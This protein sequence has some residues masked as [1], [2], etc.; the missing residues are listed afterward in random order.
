MCVCVC[1]RFLDASKVD[2]ALMTN[3]SIYECGRIVRKKK[4]AKKTTV[5]AYS[6]LRINTIAILGCWVCGTQVWRT[7]YSNTHTQTSAILHANNL[8]NLRQHCIYSCILF[9]VWSFR[10]SHIIP[11]AQVELYD[12]FVF[13]N[14]FFSVYDRMRHQLIEPEKNTSRHKDE[15]RIFFCT[16][17]FC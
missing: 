5:S 14:S 9:L 12:F 7:A 8:V 17:D 13:T 6:E 16:K 1:L 4:K 15:H 11:A 2:G 10:C 3:D